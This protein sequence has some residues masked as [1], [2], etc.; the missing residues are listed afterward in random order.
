MDLF[1]H[2]YTH[3]REPFAIERGIPI[4]TSRE[5]AQ[6]ETWERP[7]FHFDR[8]EVDDSFAVWPHEVGNLPLI[9][10]QN[11]VSGA[12]AAARKKSGYVKRFTTRQIQGQYVRCWRKE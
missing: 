3:P 1:E 8:M 11:L 5:S 6:K 10:V 12:A 7:D 2:A 4:P 9:V